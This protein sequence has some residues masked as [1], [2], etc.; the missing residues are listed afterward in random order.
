MEH[1]EK[2]HR[3]ADTARNLFYPLIP[4]V[5]VASL[6]SLAWARS[7]EAQVFLE[8]GA[9]KFDRDGYIARRDGRQG[10]HQL[11]QPNEKYLATIDDPE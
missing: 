5:V 7:L 8:R 1:S 9:V 10:L 6:W 2:W 4:I 3:F 11:P